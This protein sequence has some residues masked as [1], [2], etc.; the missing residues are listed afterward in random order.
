M[1]ILFVQ[2]SFQFFHKLQ[3]QVC[4][5]EQN[6]PYPPKSVPLTKRTR[7]V[8]KLHSFTHNRTKWSDSNFVYQM[9]RPSFFRIDETK[10]SAALTVLQASQPAN[11]KTSLS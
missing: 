2:V 1:I 11:G 4:V 3:K 5:C 6:P 9:I 7:S 10:S 8:C